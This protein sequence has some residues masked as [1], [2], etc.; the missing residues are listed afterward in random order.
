MNQRVYALDFLRTFMMLLGIFLHGVL[1]EP[2]FDFLSDQWNYQALTFVNDIIHT[3]RMPLFYL[4]SGYLSAQVLRRQRPKQF[5][6]NRF[7]KLL[8][9]L[10]LS[11]LTVGF[12][13]NLFF[14]A[15]VLSGKGYSPLTALQLSF[16]LRY[17]DFADFAP[18]HLWFLYYLSAF[19]PVMLVLH[20]ML[21][22]FSFLRSFAKA[23]NVINSRPETRPLV[24]VA[25]AIV[26]TLILFAIDSNGNPTPRSFRVTLP[27]FLPYFYYF[28]FGWCLH[29]VRFNLNYF[30]PKAGWFLAVA[31]A[32]TAGRS[33]AWSLLG[34]EYSVVILSL[35]NLSL[36]CYIFGFLGLAQSRFNKPSEVLTYLSQASY[37]IYLVHYP[38]IVFL[39]LFL[40]PT[41]GFAAFFLLLCV[42]TYLSVM[43]YNYLIR[44]TLAGVLLN[45]KK[46]A[47]FPFH[48]FLLAQSVVLRMRKVRRGFVFERYGLR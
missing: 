17:F 12:L 33:L 46:F 23:V 30:V 13:T 39:K 5:L 43:S 40:A 38:L 16:Q 35:Y 19:V 25:L 26:P 11:L 21:R 31:V 27:N 6:R 1:F 28:A 9:P 10:A 7:Q 2:K 3:F 22:W 24:I 36:L 29:W 48:R 41:I 37:W 47:P 8:L 44:P 34:W 18:V 45:G 20:L 42:V 4:L 14:H 15:L 32:L